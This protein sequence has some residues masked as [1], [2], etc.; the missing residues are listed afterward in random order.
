M[1]TP[2]NLKIIKRPNTLAIRSKKHLFAL[3]WLLLF[4]WQLCAQTSNPFSG[5]GVGDLQRPALT[6]NFSMGGTGAAAADPFQINRINP[7]SYSDLRFMTLDLSG[8]VQNTSLQTTQHK[9]QYTTGGLQGIA[10][11]FKK[12]KPLAFSAGLTPYSSSGYEFISDSTYYFPG[13]TQVVY[14]RR[15]GSGGMNELY[16]GFATKV[17][18]RRLGFG[19]DV[20][21]LF[22]RLYSD[23]VTGV[24]S[25][26][27]GQTVISKQRYISGLALRAGII[28]A[29]T[30]K[31]L[32]PDAILRTGFAMEYQPPLA[33]DR[34]LYTTQIGTNLNGSY[35]LIDTVINE[36]TTVNI[37][38]HYSVGIGID[39]YMRYALNIDASFQDWSNFR[40]EQDDRYLFA[41]YRL[42]VGAEWIPS[43]RDIRNYFARI[44]YRVGAKYEQTYLKINDN[45]IKAYGVS[46]GLGFPLSLKVPNRINLGVEYRLRGQA[47]DNLIQE[48]SFRFVFGVSFTEV[49]FSPRKYD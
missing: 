48:S 9:S 38:P 39:R 47:V 22:G 35:T 11:V 42:A 1:R 30:L 36:K 46:A 40:Y 45:A 32:A 2:L 17:L 49:W 13:D 18:K 41:T 29:D 5:F 25:P 26:N 19:L 15:R 31:F 12:A 34:Q 4:S 28:Y 10:F 20:R 44:A 43:Y 3:C 24:N 27:A 21:Y 16:A 37:P 6:R 14:S 33:T 7:A 23:W 8:F